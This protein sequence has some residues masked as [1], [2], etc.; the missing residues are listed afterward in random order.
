MLNTFQDDP[1]C[2]KPFI[3]ALG[4][5]ELEDK[6]TWL[7]PKCGCTWKAALISGTDSGEAA[8][9]HWSPV[10]MIEVLRV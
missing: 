5:N 8:I 2:N 1:C 9:K 4:K 3:R 7:C 10:P 6:D